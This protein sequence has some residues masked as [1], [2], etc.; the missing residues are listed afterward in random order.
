[1]N[2]SQPSRLWTGDPMRLDEEHV[3]LINDS[4]MIFLDRTRKRRCLHRKFSE[5]FGSWSMTII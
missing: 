3:I 5:V 1:M 2:L 4:T